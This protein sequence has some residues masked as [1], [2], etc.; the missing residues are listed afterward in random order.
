MKTARLVGTVLLAWMVCMTLAY[1]SDPTA[2][3]TRV[4]KVV[5]EPNA[6]SPQAF[7]VW[8]V[9]SMAKPDDRNDYLTPARGYLYFTLAG[10]ET[11][12]RAEW[13]D[14]KQVAGSGQ[15]VSFGSRYQLKAR[16]RPTD[17]RP[18]NPDPYPVSIGLT[19]V[20]GMTDYAPIRALATFRN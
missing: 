3:Y 10:H 8:G 17:E 14:L 9:F 7:Q 1:A 4:D 11:A 19:K 16:L 2:V 13:A 18:A 6:D 12:A 5:L 15:I 20:R